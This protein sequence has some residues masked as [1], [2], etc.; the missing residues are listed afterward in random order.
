MGRKSSRKVSR[1]GEWLVIREKTGLLTTQN[2]TQQIWEKRVRIS[3]GDLLNF[4]QN[5]L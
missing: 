3:E 4:C 2:G 1:E 5:D